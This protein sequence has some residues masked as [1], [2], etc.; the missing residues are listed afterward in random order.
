MVGDRTITNGVENA[1]RLESYTQPDPI[2]FYQFGYR[3][4]YSLIT[5]LLTG[6]DINFGK[7][8]SATL[9]SLQPKFS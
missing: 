5:E 1:A 8:T 9:M 4:Q 7:S 3:G 6:S 2:Y